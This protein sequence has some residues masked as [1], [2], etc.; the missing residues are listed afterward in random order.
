MG[1]KWYGVRKSRKKDSLGKRLSAEAF[2]R[3]AGLLGC[4]LIPEHAEFRLMGPRILED[5]KK[6]EEKNLFLRGLIPSM[7]YPY[8][9]VE[10]ERNQRKAGRSK[11]SIGKM[12]ALALEGITS[13]SIRPLRLLLTGG[14]IMTACSGS[15]EVLCLLRGKSGNEKEV[16]LLMWMLCGIQL[17]GLGILGEYVGKD[18]M[19]S[20]KRPRYLIEESLIKE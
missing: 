18:Y 2:Y 8:A 3:L 10:Y 1:P 9:I 17:I 13:F 16:P 7:G 11:Y 5:L 14:V 12:T 20:K 19:E 15:G 4:R 6:Y